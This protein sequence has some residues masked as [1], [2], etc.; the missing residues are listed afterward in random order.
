MSRTVL[1]VDDHRNVQILLEDFLTEQGYVV[2]TASNGRQALDVVRRT[3]PDLVLLDI[4]MPGMDG[5]QFISALRQASSLPVIMITARQQEGD[6]IRGF[7]LG[8]DDYI[9]KPFRLRELLV[10]MRAVLRRAGPSQGEQAVLCAGDLALDPG[11]HQV[12]QAGV[13]VEV[14]PLE[15]ALL[16]ALLEAKGQVVR[17]AE[18]CTRLIERGYA[19]SEAT[20]KIHVRN[21]RIKLGDD[22]N[23]P[24]YIES[25][26][27]VG[28]RLKEVSTACD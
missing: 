24:R 20:L 2:V 15:F 11:Q 19:G 22:A 16:E 26:F 12:T 9:T 17:R 5:Y 8:A 3:P 4:M 21:L 27:G 28:Y 14:T 10:R 7:D 1:V 18:I 25:V 6:V 23:E 13:P